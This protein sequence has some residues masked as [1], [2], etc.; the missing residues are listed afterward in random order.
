MGSLI[1]CVLPLCLICTFG[2]CK[3]PAL[4]VLIPALPT[5]GRKYEKVQPHNYTF[6]TSDQ[7]TRFIK[8]FQNNNDDDDDDDDKNDS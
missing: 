8:L 6:K 5:V 3:L 4:E 1:G 2:K 7:Q